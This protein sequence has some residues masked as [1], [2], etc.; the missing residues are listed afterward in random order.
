MAIFYDDLDEERAIVRNSKSLAT[1]NPTCDA[2]QCGRTMIW[3]F[4]CA[5][6]HFLV[7]VAVANRAAKNCGFS[8]TLALVILSTGETLE[9]APLYAFLK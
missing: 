3:S 9:N 1:K 4:A 5:V 8:S 7:T 2:A 6:T